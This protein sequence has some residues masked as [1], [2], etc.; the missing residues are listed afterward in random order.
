MPRVRVWTQS[1]SGPQW[2]QYGRLSAPLY[3]SGPPCRNC[4]TLQVPHSSVTSL[5]LWRV[6]R[7]TSC[8]VPH[9]PPTNPAAVPHHP[10][11][12]HYRYWHYGSLTQVTHKFGMAAPASLARRVFALYTD[13][14]TSSEARCGY[15][16]FKQKLLREHLGP[17]P[18]RAGTSGH[19]GHVNG[20]G[21]SHQGTWM[22]ASAA[23]K[24]RSEALYRKTHGTPRLSQRDRA[25]GHLHYRDYGPGTASGPSPSPAAEAHHYGYDDTLAA[26]LEREALDDA[27]ALLRSKIASHT[28]SKV[29]EVLSAM[30]HAF[31][32]SYSAGIP[33]ADFA[34]V[35]RHRFYVDL[36]PRQT[37]Q[38]FARYDLGLKG[39]LT[40]RDFAE[41]VLG[42]AFDDTSYR[43]SSA[44]AGQ[45]AM[46]RSS[47]AGAAG[48]ATT[49]LSGG[50]GIASSR[51]GRDA[52]QRARDAAAENPRAIA[53]LLQQLGIDGDGGRWQD[54][55]DDDGGY[56]DRESVGIQSDLRGQGTTHGGGG[57]GGSI[58]AASATSSVVVHMPSASLQDATPGVA[59]PHSGTETGTVTAVMP[60]GGTRDAG[61]PHPSHDGGHGESIDSD[62]AAT[63]AAIAGAEHAFPAS[64]H[65]GTGVRIGDG[66]VDNNDVDSDNAL[67]R[68]WA[69][70]TGHHGRPGSGRARG[71]S[72]GHASRP[73][74]HAGAA[75]LQRPPLSPRGPG[76]AYAYI[77]APPRD[78]SS[79][80]GPAQ[81]EGS[82]M[83]R[84]AERAWRQSDRGVAAQATSTVPMVPAS[85]VRPHPQRPSSAQRPATA[86]A[87][88]TRQAHT[89]LVTTAAIMQGAADAAAASAAGPA[90]HDHMRTVLSHTLASASVARKRVVDRSYRTGRGAQVDFATS[91]RPR[92]AQARVVARDSQVTRAERARTAVME[93]RGILQ[94]VLRQEMK[95]RGEAS[96]ARAAS[97][98]A[99]RGAAQRRP[100]AT[101]TAAGRV[102][103]A[104]PRR[105]ASARAG[106]RRSRELGTSGEQ[107]WGTGSAMAWTS[108]RSMGGGASPRAS[109]AGAALARRAGLT[110]DV[111]VT[112]AADGAS[113]PQVDDGA[114]GTALTSP[115]RVSS[116]G[117]GGGGGADATDGTVA[118]NGIRYDGEWVVDA[119]G[120]APKRAGNVMGASVFIRPSA[121]AVDGGKAVNVNHSSGRGGGRQYY[122]SSPYA[123]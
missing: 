31:G 46:S 48:A 26:D 24:A 17:G 7:L 39:R 33:F 23:R 19:G 92:S 5:Q 16:S 105:P 80:S 104:S 85:P 58:D 93:R 116:A 14:D 111:K 35:L 61:G 65:V 89:T 38:L 66:A 118:G 72:H 123:Y 114:A 113:V 108:I 120:G 99:T 122:R 32:G 25:P 52:G 36:T 68:A 112:R 56:V 73:Q 28:R 8:C 51:L 15:L 53:L 86:G 71:S 109:S 91:M 106:G 9:A 63:A 11:R 98:A 75:P 60:E 37:A 88:R 117:N 94:G 40:A 121:A 119:P 107:Q 67:T 49:P 55:D 18:G 30:T 21:A 45:R 101:V 62:G 100:A 3:R 22:D 77:D 41:R 44:E 115:Q 34:Y 90:S 2:A 20:G 42:P 76:G 69:T 54:D 97:A 84:D 13:G 96:K 110:L 50:D 1:R 87:S 10:L 70:R 57:G 78:R 12:S 79:L 83:G 81:T 95:R 29:H 74:A 27:E 4:N 43:A 64:G 47:R 59:A 6:H 103:P 102:V 82:R